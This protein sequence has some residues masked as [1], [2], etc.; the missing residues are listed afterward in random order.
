MLELPV[1][2]NFS[3]YSFRTNLD[4]TVYAFNVRYNERMDR[5]VFDIMTT[6]EEYIVMGVPILLGVSLLG[7][8]Q[9]ARLPTGVLFALN[10]ENEYIEAGRNDLGINV[11]LLYQPSTEI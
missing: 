8:Y 11:L 4:G 2:S 3:S 7:L 5:W 6:A 1:S 9:D 10:L